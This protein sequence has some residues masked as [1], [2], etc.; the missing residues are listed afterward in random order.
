[1]IRF[2]VSGP[3]TIAGVSNGSSASHESNIGHQ[4][5]AFHGLCLVMVRTARHPGTIT[6]T[7][8]ANGLPA[9]TLT[10]DTRALQSR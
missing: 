1:M 6:L 4:V 2:S 8:K 9:V 10:I 3:G 7:A 5:R